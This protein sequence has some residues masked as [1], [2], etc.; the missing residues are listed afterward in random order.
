MPDIINEYQK[1]K[2]QGED[3]RV[4]AKHAM[5]T[6]FRDLLSEAVRIADEYR[7]DFGAAL[8]P[9]PA[10]TAFRYKATAK[11]KAKKPAGK[12]KPPAASERPTPK[13]EP[14]AAKPSPKVSGLQKR[15]ATAKKKLEDAKAGGATT[16]PYEDKVYEIEDELRLAMQA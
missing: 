16:R 10:V 3:L 8:K 13:A 6:R 7:A 1:W 12:A 9:P 2:Q 15:L 14:P 5:E 4:Q 11:L